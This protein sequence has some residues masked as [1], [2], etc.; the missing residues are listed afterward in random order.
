MLRRAVPPA[1]PSSKAVPNTAQKDA[2]HA[3]RQLGEHLSEFG[4]NWARC[5]P[6]WSNAGQSRPNLAPESWCRNW[7]GQNSPKLG[8]NCYRSNFSARFRRL[9]S[10]TRPRPL[11][12]RRHHSPTAA[13]ARHF[14]KIC[15]GAHPPEAAPGPAIDL[16]RT[17]KRA[18]SPPSV[19]S[20][21][22]RP[23][24][25]W[26]TPALAAAWDPPTSPP[27]SHRPRR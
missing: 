26:P 24:V 8:R 12:A 7:I 5:R 27:P 13:L 19:L 25:I 1:I 23:I 21:R 17:P 20:K 15:P 18:R 16:L 14:R 6:K 9:H 10:D 22:A 4:Q 2:G 11:Q 3:L